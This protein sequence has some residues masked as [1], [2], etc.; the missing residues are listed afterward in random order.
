MRCTEYFLLVLS[1]WLTKIC[2]PGDSRVRHLPIMK[3]VVPVVAFLSVQL[4]SAGFGAY[5]SCV[6]NVR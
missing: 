5:A 1:R 3:G 6:D 4:L 2:Q